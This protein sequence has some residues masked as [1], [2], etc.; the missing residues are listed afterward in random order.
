M[1]TENLNSFGS[2]PTALMQDIEATS[3][4]LKLSV[5][6]VGNR[7]ARFEIIRKFLGEAWTTQSVLMPLAWL[8]SEHKKRVSRKALEQ[9]QSLAHANAFHQTPQ[10][11]NRDHTVGKFLNL[12]PNPEAMVLSVKIRALEPYGRI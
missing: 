8:N 10:F 2:D 4:H 12:S 3:K 6:A 9:F 11:G 7:G 1:A 5:T